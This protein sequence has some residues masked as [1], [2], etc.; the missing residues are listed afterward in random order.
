MLK[1]FILLCGVIFTLSGC[2]GENY[3]VGHPITTINNGSSSYEL[4]PIFVAWQTQ[5]DQTSIDSNVSD[6][7]LP[8][9]IVHSDEYIT[10][11]FSDSINDEGEY[12]DVNIE[13]FAVQQDKE[14][15]LYET[16]EIT[17]YLEE[18]HSFTVP[19]EVGEFL[20]EVHFSSNSNTAEYVGRLLVE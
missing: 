5:G 3:S 19:N 1:K 10:L 11:Q 2:I 13:V 15:L 20:L 17:S 7:S 6:R 14:Q 9:I 12:T 8:N 16:T 4:T 18:K